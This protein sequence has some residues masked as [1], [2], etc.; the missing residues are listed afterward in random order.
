[1]KR[2]RVHAAF[3]FVALLSAGATA[4]E[5]IRFARADRID[6]EIATIAADAL[7]RRARAGIEP[8]AADS[9]HAGG[10]PVVAYLAEGAGEAP[11]QIVLAR[12]V[13]LAAEGNFPE[14]TRRYESLLEAG[15]VDEIGRAAL[16]DLGN[17]YLRQ[18]AGTA[19][20]A[21]RSLPL[22]EQAKAHYRALLRVAPGD[23]DAR[24]NLERALRLAP[25][26]AAELDAAGEATKHHVTLRGARSDDL[27]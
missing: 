18:G 22:I 3:A 11:R 2:A 1:M 26:G 16:F 20:D 4:Y 12:A 13:A 6:S 5:A 17:A 9:S 23:W 27:P 21:P 8:A 25:E 10:S 24:Y 14:A 7:A 19:A 15:P